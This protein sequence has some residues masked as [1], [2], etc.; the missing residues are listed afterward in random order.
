VNTIETNVHGTEIVLRAAAKKRKRIVVTSTSEVYGKSTS[1][2]FREDADLV[3]GATT[4]GRW[5]YACSKALDEFLAL[6]YFHEKRVPATVVRLFNTVGPRQ[7]G[8]YGMVIPNFVRQALLGEPITVY[9]DGKQCRC[10]GY[11]G[12]VVE[13]FVRIAE[14]SLVAGEVFNIGND[15]EISIRALAELVRRAAG[16]TSDIIHV[17]YDEAYG[18]GFEDM[19]RRVPSLAKTERYLGYRPSTPLKVILEGVVA[20]TRTRLLEERDAELATA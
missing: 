5:S 13:T 2:P 7:T 8:R 6:A 20:D 18:S 10:F 3:I 16:S 11:V 19:F 9:G 17:P 15:E 14:S 4:R 1:V 12:D